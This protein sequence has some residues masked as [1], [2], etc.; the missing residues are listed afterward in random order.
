M[1]KLSDTLQRALDKKK[2]I[3]HVDSLDA[4]TKDTAS[5]KVKATPPASKKPAIR[6]AGRGR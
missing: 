1:S 6:P 3:T 2:G 5:K 4:A